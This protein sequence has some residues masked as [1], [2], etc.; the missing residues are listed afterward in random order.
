MESI[1]C[2][3]W[4]PLAA[5]TC[6]GPGYTD[7]G[8]RRH[9]RRRVQKHECGRD[10][11]AD[12][13]RPAASVDDNNVLA[14]AI[15]PGAP[16]TLY[17]GTLV[18][19]FKSTNGGAS[20]LALGGGLPSL[21]ATRMP[22]TALV[23]VPGNPRALYAGTRGNGVYRSLD[24]GASWSPFNSG[25]PNLDIHS[26]AALPGPR[27]LM[28]AGTAGA[29]VFRLDHAIATRPDV[30]GDYAV[31]SID[32]LCILR[33]LGGFGPTTNCPRPLPFPDVTSMGP[34]TRWMHSVSSV[35]WATSR[36]QRPA[37][38]RRPPPPCRHAKRLPTWNPD[39]PTTTVS[40]WFTVSGS[41]LC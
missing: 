18:G 36:H 22:V 41:R 16:N 8:L 34:S 2:W 38:Y 1:Q 20:W 24:G 5:I 29:G 19:G 33:D 23:L 15:D 37:R 9:G 21:P 31:T 32:A 17:A 27:A 26:L 25:L 10:L 35:L 12:Q 40:A 4:R 13:Q 14:I 7:D 39:I 28:L 3:S 11:D 30:N 6:S